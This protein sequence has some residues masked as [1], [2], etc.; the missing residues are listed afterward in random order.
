MTE[1]NRHDAAGDAADAQAPRDRQGDTRQP[2]VVRSRT[3]RPRA[4]TE[5]PRSDAKA[6]SEGDAIAQ[7]GDAVGGPA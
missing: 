1:D 3:V 4:I 5:E 7:G 2:R 6:I